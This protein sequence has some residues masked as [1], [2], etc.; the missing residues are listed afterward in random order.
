MP[1]VE[2]TYWEGAGAGKV[3][4]H[5]LDDAWLAGHLRVPDRI[6]DFG[7]GYGRVLQQLHEAGWVNTLGVDRSGS[8]IERGRRRFPH[9]DLRTFED[10]PLKQP[11]GAFDAALLIAVLTCI[12]DDA[13]KPR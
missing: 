6:L 7:C 11:D 8:L 1:S 9:L 12:P 13:D 10:L 5:P 2:R 3:F 4:T